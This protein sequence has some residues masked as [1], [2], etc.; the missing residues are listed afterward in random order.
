[1]TPFHFTRVGL[2]IP[3]QI[4]EPQT[5]A[6]HTQTKKQSMNSLAG[7]QRCGDHAAWFVGQDR[8]PDRHKRLGLTNQT[9]RWSRNRQSPYTQKSNRPTTTFTLPGGD[10][11]VVRVGSRGPWSGS[12]HR[13]A[14]ARWKYSNA[15]GVSVKSVILSRAFK[16]NPG[17]PVVMFFTRFKQTDD[18]K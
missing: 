8:R 16:H 4:A 6:A 17:I 12:E 15:Q 5:P 7:F 13:F 1:M 2:V 9:A 10:V 18:D 14:E 11:V 3:N